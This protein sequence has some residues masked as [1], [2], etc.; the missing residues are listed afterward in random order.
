MDLCIPLYRINCKFHQK[1]QQQ[2]AS[3]CASTKK[4]EARPNKVFLWWSIRVSKPY[5]PINWFQLRLQVLQ[6]TMAN[7]T[8][9]K[10]KKC[11]L[12]YRTRG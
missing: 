9:M 11:I 12:I 5:S 8:E 7:M 3:F 6:T 4:N 2:T 1:K 10:V